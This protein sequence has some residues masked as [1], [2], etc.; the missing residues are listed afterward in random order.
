MSAK[1]VMLDGILFDSGFEA[2]VYQEMKLDPCVI[3]LTRP[4]KGFFQCYVKGK[5]VCSYTPDFIYK[6]KETG[7]DVVL[8]TKGFWRP[9]ARLRYKLADALFGDEYSFKVRMQKEK[10]RR[11]RRKTAK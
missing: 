2:E 3:G 6:D 9:E 4:K 10:K 8:E 7:E 1:K 5:K 11:G